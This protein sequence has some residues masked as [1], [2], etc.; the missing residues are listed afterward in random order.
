MSKKKNNKKSQTKPLSKTTQAKID[1]L[2]KKGKSRGFVTDEEILHYFPKIDENVELLETIYDKLEVAGIEVKSSY[3]L[4]EKTSPTEDEQLTS[5]AELDDAVQKYLIEIGRYPLLSPEEEREL[6]QRM[7]KGDKEARERLIKSNLRLVVSIAKKY[8]GRSRGLTFMDLIQHGTLGLLKAVDRFDWRK[9]FK[10]STYATWWIRQAINRAL[11]DEA[12]TIR[13]PVHIVEA[14]YRMNKVKK[15]LEAIL[16]RQPTPEEL[17]A[18][19]NLPLSK[20]QVLLKYTSDVASL[21]APVSEE[22]EAPVKDII[23]DETS[24]STE[25][26]AEL[27]LLREKLK[28]L[29]KDLPPREQKVLELRYG[30]SGPTHT[31]DE[32]GKIF[33][34]TRE[35]VRQIEIKA[36]QMLRNHELIERLREILQ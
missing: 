17:A 3:D 15:R 23:P 19:M 9:G 35:R 36:I 1:E 24:I 4:W 33:G 22:M 26:Y 16:N 6:A 7:S 13:I 10:F 8:I 31:L 34:I 11:A 20:V 28:E 30:L 2:I 18:E 27:Q 32:I 14:L 21:E 25:K 5:L 12:R 29:I